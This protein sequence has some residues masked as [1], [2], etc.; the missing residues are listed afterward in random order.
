MDKSSLSM[1][2]T[3]RV[4]KVGYTHYWKRVEKF[5]KQQFEKVV[6]DFKAVLKHL[7]EFVPLA[8]GLGE[9]EP[10]INSKRIWFNG[11][12]NCGHTDRNL[13]ITWPDK[14]ASGIAFVAKRYKDVPTRTLLTTLCGQEEDLAVNDSDVSGTW[15][16]G[17]KLKH[18]SCAGDCS[19]ETFSLPVRIEKED[20][21]K[22]IGKISHYDANGK[23]VYNDTE[24]VGR[25]FEFC[26][27]AYKPYD[28]AVIICLIIAKHHLK[29][30]II[31]T[32]DGTLDNWKDGMLICQK[33]L[34]YGLDFTLN[35]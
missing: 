17:L 5:D 30:E 29:E 31:E 16:A 35:D 25:Y 3:K 32:S 1:T 23:P 15:F 12:Q 10:E 6:R 34:G 18:R 9:S 4:I 24:E 27:T 7:S 33:I 28:L 14:N 26:K 11:M 13:G 21:Q 8:G 20:W 22:P 2:K 19:H